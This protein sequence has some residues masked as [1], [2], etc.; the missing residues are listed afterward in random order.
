MRKIKCS[1]SRR[2]RDKTN[3]Q[4]RAIFSYSFYMS[5]G[6]SDILGYC[7]ERVY[8]L[9]NHAWSNRHRPER[10]CGRIYIHYYT[11]YKIIYKSVS[12]VFQCISN[13][14]LVYPKLV[15]VSEEYIVLR[16]INVDIH[17]I[18]AYNVY[19]VYYM[20]NVYITFFFIYHEY[21]CLSNIMLF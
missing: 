9:A 7:P 15:C 11:L 6:V 5:L 18:L 14:S 21:F 17:F 1:L 3:S 10:D 8:L 2:S 12:S 20:Y 19:N 16:C 13:V 4:R